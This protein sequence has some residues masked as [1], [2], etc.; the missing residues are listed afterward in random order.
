MSASAPRAAAHGRP[1]VMRRGSSSRPDRPAPETATVAFSVSAN[2]G[3][4]RTGYHHD[5][6]THLPPHS[7][8][9]LEPVAVAFSPSPSPSPPSSC[10]YSISPTSQSVLAI[11]G[12]GTV[13]V[14]TAG[15]CAWTATSQASWLTV[16]AG[17]TGG[18]NGSVAFTAAVNDGASRTGTITIAGRTFTV[19]QAAAVVV[20]CEVLDIAEQSGRGSGGGLSIGECLH[21]QPVCVDGQQQPLVD[22]HHVRF[23][24]HRQWNRDIQ[25]WQERGREADRVVDGGRT[26]RQS[27]ARTR[28]PM[29]TTRPPSRSRSLP[30]V[31]GTQPFALRVPHP[32]VL[33]RVLPLLT[34]DEMPVE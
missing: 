31:R 17:A 14:S 16:T 27:R 13:S 6:R 7:R 12:V 21:N 28:G 20:R 15:T 2:A 19:T 9:C 4:P 29:T 30:I 18:G 10:T 33:I 1:A 3:A 26:Q 25:R 23:E 24:R 22:H 8:R 5:C 32:S 11:G 34:T